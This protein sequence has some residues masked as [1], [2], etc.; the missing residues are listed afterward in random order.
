MFCILLRRCVRRGSFN[1]F[2]SY[3]GSITQ[4]THLHTHI[5]FIA[6][7]IKL[8]NCAISSQCYP[9]FPSWVETHSFQLIIIS[10][11]IAHLRVISALRLRRLTL[12]IPLLP[13][14]SKVGSKKRHNTI[15]LVCARRLIL[16]SLRVNILFRAGYPALYNTLLIL[17]PYDFVIILFPSIRRRVLRLLEVPANRRN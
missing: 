8:Q 16:I 3:F 2:P 6:A 1:V 17:S 7:D 12:R 11:Q 4:C 13:F 14:L 5:H 15:F 9:S 10:R